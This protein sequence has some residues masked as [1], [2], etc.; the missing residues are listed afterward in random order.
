MS[1]FSTL[2]YLTLTLI[3]HIFALQSLQPGVVNFV[4]ATTTVSQASS[5]E[6][7]S[8]L[9]PT[10]HAI[11]SASAELSHIYTFLY[12]PYKCSLCNSN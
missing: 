12:H 2:N 8:I 1:N 4:L 5:N 7:N 10:F 6:F 9:L 3:H 11:F